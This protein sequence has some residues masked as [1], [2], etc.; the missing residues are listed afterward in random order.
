[1]TTSK[2]TVLRIDGSAR[3]TGSTTRTLSDEL[4]NR[5]QPSRIIVRDLA[6]GLPFVDEEWVGANFTPSDNRNTAQQKKLTLSDMLISE[7]KAA[8]KIVLGL[9]AYNFGVPA[10]VKAWVDMIARAR[11]T[12]RYTENGPEGLLTG[13]KAYIIFASGGTPVGSDHD[14]VTSYMKHVL[15]FIGITDVTI[16]AADKQ[17]SNGELAFASARK[18]ITDI[19]EALNSVAAA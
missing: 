7:L 12:F 6:D 14:F 11:V 17:G 3:R 2:Q 18:Q 16:I 9:P 19:I 13:K 5:L 15:G 10:T 1:M 8:D 4:I